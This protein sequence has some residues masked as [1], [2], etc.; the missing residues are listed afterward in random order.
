M[1]AGQLL[2]EGVLL[3]RDVQ[4]VLLALG[5]VQPEPA[6]HLRHEPV[7]ARP[8]GRETWISRTVSIRSGNI[9]QLALTVSEPGDGQALP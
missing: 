5:A 8:G 3:R 6:G 1:S 7:R 4:R 9:V 2:A